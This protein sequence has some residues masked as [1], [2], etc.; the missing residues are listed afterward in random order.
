MR[1]MFCKQFADTLVIGKDESIPSAIA[2]TKIHIIRL[3][4]GAP[5]L[6]DVLTNTAK[7]ITD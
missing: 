2:P 1:T 3:N 7:K 5:G 4:I 6:V